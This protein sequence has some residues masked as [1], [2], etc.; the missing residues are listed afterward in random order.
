MKSF[1]EYVKERKVR[2]ASPDPAEARSL[3]EQARARLN[4]VRSLPL[5]EKNASFRFEDAYESLR[6]AVQ[7]FMALEGFKPYSHEAIVAYAHEKHLLNEREIFTFDR[8]REQRNDINYRGQRISVDEAKQIIS[9]SRKIILRLE[10]Q[11]KPT[12][13]S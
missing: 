11:F 7:A 3:L 1:N 6:E 2:T 12:T 5:Q 4:D 13:E 8:Y 10:K 9:F